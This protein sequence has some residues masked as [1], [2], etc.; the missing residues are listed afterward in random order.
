MELSADQVLALAGSA[1]V[2][3]DSVTEPVEVAA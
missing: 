2:L 3:P 1:R